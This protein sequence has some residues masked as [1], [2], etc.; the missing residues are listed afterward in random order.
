MTALEQQIAR[1]EL[2]SATLSAQLKTAQLAL[3]K[4]ETALLESDATLKSLNSNYLSLNDSWETEKKRVQF[5]KTTTA[6]AIGVAGAELLLLFLAFLL[7]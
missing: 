7:P 6:I 1:S 3:E 5:Y 2:A 4:S